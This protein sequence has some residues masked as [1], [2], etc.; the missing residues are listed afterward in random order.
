MTSIIPSECLARNCKWFGGISK[1]NVYV[2]IAFPEGIPDDISFGDNLHEENIEGDGGYKYI[3][4]PNISNTKKK[5]I[6][7]VTLPKGFYPEDI[8]KENSSEIRVIRFDNE[9]PY[10]IMDCFKMF[11][12]RIKDKPTISKMIIVDDQ[13]KQTLE[14]IKLK[15]EFDIERVYTKALQKSFDHFRKVNSGFPTFEERNEIL[16]TI[17]NVIAKELGMAYDYQENS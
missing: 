5:E 14:I 7:V 4:S 6:K 1:E 3:Q 12:E 13:V 8:I 10:N 11:Y 17:N 9:N 15:E 2:C 16:K